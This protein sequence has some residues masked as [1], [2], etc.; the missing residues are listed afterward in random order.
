[1]SEMCVEDED[2]DEDRGLLGG[3][4][5]I[6]LTFWR[7]DSPLARDG[8]RCAA[9]LDYPFRPFIMY[10]CMRPLCMCTTKKKMPLIYRARCV[11]P[12]N[13]IRP[14]RSFFFVK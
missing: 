4:C 6:M 14:R 2:E 9:A 11:L 5:S 3:G 8:V 10:A 1:M 13:T 12:H 7:N